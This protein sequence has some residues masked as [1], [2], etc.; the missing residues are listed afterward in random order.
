MCMNTISDIEQMLEFSAEQLNDAYSR[1]DLNNQPWAKGTAKEIDVIEKLAQFRPEATILDVG[2]G[3]GRHSIELAKRG[4]KVVGV[5][6]SAT[7]IQKAKGNAEGLDV[8]FQVWDAR[9]RLPGKAFDYVICLYDVI[10]S[11]R[12]LEDNVKIVRRIAQKLRKGGVAVISV[13]NMMHI[14]LR[15]VRRGNVYQNPR[16]LLEL[17]ASNNMQKRGDMFD[18]NYQL[19]DEDA[20]LVYHKEQFERDG[21]LSAEYVVADYRFTAAE[22]SEVLR[23]NGFEIQEQ[24]FVSAGHF[25]V[26]LT[27]DNDR[28]KE[29]LFVVKKL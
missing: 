20:H 19:L 11:Y 9:K 17:P 15:A 16:L 14:L 3:Q 4:Y 24:R 8:T 6:A 1:M 13:M 18:V 26:S 10:G 2:C 22:L 28:A 5:D 29:C 27:E 12:S 7:H 23:F 21:L 25:D